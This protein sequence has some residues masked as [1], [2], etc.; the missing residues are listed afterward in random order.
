MKT[1]KF[2]IQELQQTLAKLPTDSA[3]SSLI[4]KEI[5]R[6]KLKTFDNK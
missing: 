2:I 3:A 5:V 4:W 6:L 1:D